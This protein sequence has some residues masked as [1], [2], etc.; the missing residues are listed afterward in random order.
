MA[1][2]DDRTV[3]RV[4]IQTQFL[5]GHILMFFKS[6]KLTIEE[7]RYNVLHVIETVS[8]SDKLQKLEVMSIIARKRDRLL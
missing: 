4:T 1:G 6:I 8:L 3:T 5:T 2:N 7:Q